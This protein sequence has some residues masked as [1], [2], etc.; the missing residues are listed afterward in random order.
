MGKGHNNGPGSQPCKEP[1]KEIRTITGHQAKTHARL[2]AVSLQGL[3]ESRRL[4][5]QVAEGYQ[6]S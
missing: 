5:C 2:D 4:G 6:P 1:H 3:S